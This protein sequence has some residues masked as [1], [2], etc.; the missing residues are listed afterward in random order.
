MNRPIVFGRMKGLFQQPRTFHWDS[1]ISLSF[2][3]KFYR[4]RFPHL[5]R[6]GN[7]I[8]QNVIV[9]IKLLIIS[10]VSFWICK[11][12]II[13][14]DF[15]PERFWLKTHPRKWINVHERVVI[16][17]NYYTYYNWTFLRGDKYLQ[18][19]L[20][21]NFANIYGTHIIL[22]LQYYPPSK[23]LSSTSSTEL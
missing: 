17:F 20:L 2:S 14:V 23:S 7:K 3:A 19:E 8:Q 15:I 4:I 11:P 12:F 21:A 6:L 22:D 13:C 5:L 10:Y 18:A 16:Q 1:C 9:R